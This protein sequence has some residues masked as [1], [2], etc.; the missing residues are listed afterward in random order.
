M[1]R[2]KLVRSKVSD[3]AVTGSWDCCQREAKADNCVIESNHGSPI[4][5]GF[6]DKSMVVTTQSRGLVNSG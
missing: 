6:F 5:Q 1:I 2:E 4:N 3:G